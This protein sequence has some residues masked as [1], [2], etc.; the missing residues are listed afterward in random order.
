MIYH[1]VF[2]PKLKGA[3]IF[4]VTVPSQKQQTKN[5]FSAPPSDFI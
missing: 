4:W 2:F 5:L 3:R 1:T